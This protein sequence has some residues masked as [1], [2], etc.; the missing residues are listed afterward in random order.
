MKLM[1]LNTFLIEAGT[2]EYGFFSAPHG[3]ER[4]EPNGFSICAISVAVRHENGNWHTIEQSNAI[5]NRIWWNNDVV[6]GVIASPDFFNQPVKIVVF[7]E[8]VLG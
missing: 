7:A 8:P 6:A 4:F 2:D 3:L 1:A 5:D